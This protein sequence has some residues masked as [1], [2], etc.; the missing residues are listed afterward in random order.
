MCSTDNLGFERAAAYDGIHSEDEIAINE[1][2]QLTEICPMRNFIK[3]RVK[4]AF[5]LAKRDPA[6]AAAF[7]TDVLFLTG[8]FAL[9][10]IACDSCRG[11]V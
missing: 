9:V 3:R 2:Q 11:C 10:L 5:A 1:L 7:V 8:I 6:R 4:L